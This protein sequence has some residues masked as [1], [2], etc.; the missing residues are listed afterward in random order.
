MD[1]VCFAVK[2]EEGF[3]WCGLNK[4]DKQLRKAQLFHSWKWAIEARDRKCGARS[5][6]IVKVRIT[7]EYDYNPDLEM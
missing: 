5:T 3:Y 2:D 4:W 7:E 1:D 6:R